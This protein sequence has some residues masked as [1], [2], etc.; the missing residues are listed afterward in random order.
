MKRQGQPFVLFTFNSIPEVSSLRCFT[1][2]ILLLGFGAVHAEE[3]T[4]EITQGVEG[5]PTIAVVPFGSQGDLPEDIAAIVL[6][7]LARSGIF[8]PVSPDLLPARPTTVQQV[9][10]PSLRA[11]KVDFITVGQVSSSGD[12]NY[13]VRFQLADAIK[14]QQLLGYSFDVPANELRR[15]AHQISDLIYETLT[16]ERGAFTTLIAYI[17]AS[18]ATNGG[19]RYSLVVADADGHNSHTVLNS[20]DPLMSPAW[21]PDGNRLAYVSFE[22]RRSQV[23]VQDIY[24]GEREIIARYPG[25]NG[26]PAWSPDGQRLALTLSKDGNPEIYSYVLANGSLSRLTYNSAIDTEAVWAPDGN[27]IVFTSDRGGGPQLYSMGVNGGLPERLTFEGDYN[28]DAAFSPDG[29][30]LA[31]VHRRAGE[32]HIAVMDR[33]RGNIDLLTPGRLDE[34]P[35]FAPNGSIIIYATQQAEQG[36]L[37]AVS[38][39]GRVQQSLVSRNSDVREPAWSPFLP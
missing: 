9:N 27:S 29:R 25:L 3:L 38:V 13:R 7:D 2:I 34:S 5:A 6:A 12:G 11:L 22:G 8:N 20:A 26:A 31:M 14:G 28:A 1:L 23:V 21:S 16:N 33:E 15:V 39:D 10:F 32:F 37:A 30:L 19:R 4:I 36:I 35:S 17:T 24:T 18:Q